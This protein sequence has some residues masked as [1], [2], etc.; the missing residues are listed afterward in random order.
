MLNKLERKFGRYA[1][2]NL[3]LYLVMGYVAGY[4]L[5]FASRATGT[6]LLGML[7]LEPL[8]IIQKFQIWRLVTWIIVP[9]N[10]SLLFALIMCYMYYQLGMVLEQTWGAFKFNLYIFSGMLFTIIGAFVLFYGMLI[11]KHTILDIGVIGANFSTYYIN[12]SIFLAFAV[13][14]PDMQVMLYFIIPIKMKWMSIVYAVILGYECFSYGWPTRVVIISSLLNFI[15]FYLSTRKD[16]IV[17]PK[18]FKRRNDFKKATSAQPKKDMSGN[19]ISRHRCC[20]CGRTE[21]TN[22]E[23]DFRFCS[24]CEGN[25]EYCS[26]HIFTHQHKKIQ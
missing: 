24:K 23:L 16:K 6:N 2:H 8:L 3:M 15:V 22:P 10:Q 7:T 12:M 13:M 5:M 25:Y 4:I 1:I 9:P 20:V 11:F 17:S 18:E 21:L 26:E 19:P 14:Y